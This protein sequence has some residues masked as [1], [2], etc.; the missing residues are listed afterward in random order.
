MNREWEFEEVEVRIDDHSYS[1]EGTYD[2]DW[3]DNGI[4]GY[5]YWGARGTHHQ[6]EWELQNIAFTAYDENGN[7][8]QDEVI[9]RKIESYLDGHLSD[10]L[11][12]KEAPEKES[13]DYE[14]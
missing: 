13:D 8:V 1:T 6:W 14:E 3:V 5:E 12:D 7:E 10:L 4:G 11:S 2:A 9:R